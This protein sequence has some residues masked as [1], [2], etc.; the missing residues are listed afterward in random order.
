MSTTDEVGGTY[1]LFIERGATD[2]ITVGALGNVEFPAGW[3]AYVGSANG[4]GGFARIDRHARVAAGEHEAAHWHVDYL[5][6]DA[7]TTLEWDR[8]SAGADGECA[9]AR[10]L[11]TAVGATPGGRVVEGFGASDCSCGSHLLYAQRRD[12]LLDA[13]DRAHAAIAEE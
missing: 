12:R 4:A 3:Y 8:R 7:E 6:R 5:L 13:V 1:T 11:A 9:I 2:F 10:R